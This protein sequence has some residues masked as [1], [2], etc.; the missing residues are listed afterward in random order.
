M[1]PPPLKFTLILK[2]G[3]ALLETLFF[4]K[5]LERSQRSRKAFLTVFTYE[6][7]FNQ[8]YHLRFDVVVVVMGRIRRQIFG[9]LK[10]F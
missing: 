3:D 10:L 5:K 2:T 1:S 9:K 6:I 4:K 7:D 8:Y